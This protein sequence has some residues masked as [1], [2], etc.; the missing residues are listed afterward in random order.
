MMPQPA[1]PAPPTEEEQERR[2]KE[3]EKEKDR[4]AFMYA[5]SEM[6]FVFL[7]FI[8]IGII[9]A[10]RGEFS[11]LFF[12]PEWSI[13]SAVIAGQAVVKFA[14]AGVGVKIRVQKENFVFLISIVLVCLLVP[15][16]IVL[17]LALTSPSVSIKLATA[18][19]VLFLFSAIIFWFANTIIHYVNSD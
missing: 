15:I 14:S 17:A 13:V 8:V 5:S 3:I 2:R 12:V 7:P 4:R 16:L 9:L 1:N 10:H 19:A 6:L 11:T 18:Q